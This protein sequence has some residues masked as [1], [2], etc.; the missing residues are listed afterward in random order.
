MLRALV[1]IQNQ[2]TMLCNRTKWTERTKWKKLK[3][4]KKIH[5]L[6]NKKYNNL[7]QN[8]LGVSLEWDF[9]RINKGLNEKELTAKEWKKKTKGER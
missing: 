2:M 1:L 4:Y 8:L 7:W 6:F 5:N 9:L 3:Y